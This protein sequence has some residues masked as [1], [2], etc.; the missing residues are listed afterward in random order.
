[1][2][3]TIAALNNS[4]TFEQDM[5][6]VY[7]TPSLKKHFN[8]DNLA[9]WGQVIT[10]IT[11]LTLFP[12]ISIISAIKLADWEGVQGIITSNLLLMDGFTYTATEVG[13]K[14]ALWSFVRDIGYACL[15]LGSILTVGGF[16]RTTTK[17]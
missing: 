3:E 2:S 9:K 12:I 6:I 13:Q 10:G 11:L 8:W 1:M 17:A 15:V 4:P 5:K 7:T 14:I 16:N